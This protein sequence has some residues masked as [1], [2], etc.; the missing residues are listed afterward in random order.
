MEMQFKT[1]VQATDR[2]QI[3]GQSV[4]EVMKEKINWIIDKVQ[5]EP[6]HIVWVSKYS[7]MWGDGIF[8][9]L[10]KDDP[11]RLGFIT[12]KEGLKIRD[13]HL[14]VRRPSYKQM[15]VM[16]RMYGLALQWPPAGLSHLI[17]TAFRQ[18]EKM[19]IEEQSNIRALPCKGYINKQGKL[20][21]PGW[22]KTEDYASNMISGYFFIRVDEEGID[23]VQNKLVDDSDIV[24]QLQFERAKNTA[25]ELKQT[26]VLRGES[27]QKNAQM[28][29]LDM[30]DYLPLLK[31]NQTISDWSLLLDS[32]ASEKES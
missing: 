27:I 23:K 25:L 31:T 16:Q 21:Q 19:L 1:K 13:G 12:K 30:K 26:G 5:N 2:S 22:N 14:N 29:W 6:P 15:D 28:T 3:T 7:F 17:Q 8:N 4:I 32:K 18:S 24:F 10:P 11:L 9:T 20:V